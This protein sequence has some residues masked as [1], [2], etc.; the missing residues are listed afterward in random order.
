[1]GRPAI[2]R[3]LASI[4]LVALGATA[5]VERVE[6]GQGGST[7]AST[8]PST[9]AN[10]QG[11][12]A[13]NG[14]PAITGYEG[15]KVSFGTIPD[16]PKQATG[17]P[18]KV[19][20]IN[21]ENTPLGS[22]PELRLGAQAAVDFINRELGGVDGRPLEL[23]PCIT[24]F[25]VEKSQQCAQDLVQQDVV[26]VTGGIDITSSGS[27][28][29]L[30]QNNLPYIGGI[31]VNF[32]E[33]Q[34]PMSFQFSGGAP[35]AF[36]AFAKH[37]ADTGAKKVV[38]AYADY[39]PIKSAAVDYGVRTLEKLGVPEIVEVPFPV[40][41]TDLLPVITKAK[42]SG[43]D[44]VFVGAADTACAPAM[45]NAHDL[46]LTSQMYL[47]GACAAPNIADQI[48]VE[49]V[50]GRIF[51]IEN[52][53]DPNDLE[54]AMYFAAVAKHGSPELPAASAATI[55]FRNVMNLYAL[56]VE[57]GPDNITKETLLEKVR[58]SRNRP[59]FAG[60][61]YTCD[62]AQMPDLRAL[63]A[64][65]QILVKRTGDDLTPQTDWIDVPAIVQAPAQ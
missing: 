19:G 3:I 30:E 57:L 64:P 13:A 50:E 43:A 4:A 59:S 42:E 46:G 21:Q 20:M 58:A 41:A 31:P 51:N 1:M 17:N 25:S 9:P 12:S 14:P 18:I 6:S 32:T 44:A 24:T 15:E 38:V 47:V 37:A 60:H 27:I 65:Q 36:V 11:G 61:P 29:V 39:P 55:S 33:M 53:S 34:S 49:A 5:C 7:G 28:P 2:R 16:A 56:M 10:V 35:G 63:C 8:R 45:K 40:T 23:S 26:A 48:G 54:T 22:F 52:P 62:G